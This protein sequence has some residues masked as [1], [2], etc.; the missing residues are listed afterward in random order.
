MSGE[1][2]CRAFWG[3]GRARWDL[4]GKLSPSY[5][6][7]LQDLGGKCKGHPKVRQ[8]TDKAQKSDSELNGSARRNS[9]GLYE[10]E[11][12]GAMMDIDR[13]GDK[14]LDLYHIR[15]LV[16]LKGVTHIYQRWG[17][18]AEVGQGVPLQGLGFL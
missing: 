16:E 6:G 10:S 1:L 14:Q 9:G 8:A 5:E 2:D 15:Q 12:A 3:G 4:G 18:L 13:S 17:K 11:R 7:T